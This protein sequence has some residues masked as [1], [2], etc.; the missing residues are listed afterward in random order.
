MPDSRRDPDQ[1]D[2]EDPRSHKLVMHNRKTL[3][4]VRRYR[5]SIQ[6][7]YQAKAKIQ[8]MKSDKEKQND[9]G[10][11]LNRIKPISRVGIM[12]IV[13]TRL[14][15]NHESINCMINQRNEDTAN[16]HEQDVRDR[17]KIFDGA[18]EIGWSS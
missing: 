17:L 16:F 12:Q 3:V 5:H 1:I 4:R 11:A 9:A 10:N 8:H 13:R 7:R 2:H 15:R 14:D 18:V 6:A